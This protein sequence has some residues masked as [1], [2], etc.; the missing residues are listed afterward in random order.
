MKHLNLYD[1]EH[2]QVLKDIT[3]TANGG[4]ILGIAGIA[5]SGQRQLLESISGLQQLESGEIIFKNPKKDRPVTFFHKSMKKV[6]ELGKE[7]AFHDRKR[8]GGFLRGPAPE[9]DPEAGGKREG[10]VQGG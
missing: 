4:E 2:V 5:G 7:H 6:Q 10:A 1:E 9:G 3:F 8:P